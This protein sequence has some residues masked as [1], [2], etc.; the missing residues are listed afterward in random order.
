[1]AFK[2]IEE[3]TDDELKAAIKDAEGECA[4]AGID[5]WALFKG[6]DSYNEQRRRKRLAQ[7]A[8]S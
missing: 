1:M 8:C 3:Y 2:K 5:W 4:K 6:I 7:A